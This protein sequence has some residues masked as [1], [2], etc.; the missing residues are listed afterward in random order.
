MTARA[1]PRFRPALRLLIGLAVFAALP[2]GA[3]WAQSS[4]PRKSPRKWAVGVDLGVALGG[5]T[6]GGSPGQ[7]FQPGVTFTAA[8]GQPSRSIPSWFYG[9]G[10]ILFNQVQA[11][12]ASRY[13]QHFPAITPIDPVLTG[14]SGHRSGAVPSFALRATRRI[15]PRYAIDFA[16][17]HRGSGLEL[18]GG[19]QSALD[20]A[21]DNFQAALTGLIGTIPQ[22]DVNVTTS[23]TQSKSGGGQSSLTAEAVITL[24]TRGK[25]TVHAIAGGGVLFRGDGS[26]DVKLTGAYTFSIFG[27]FPINETD[28]VT[29]HL[30]ESG[31]SA[32]GAVGGGITYDLTP[33][34]GIRVDGRLYLSSS[35][36]TTH[37]DARPTVRRVSPGSAL[38]SETTPSIQFSTVPNI[39]TSLSGAATA[40]NT[41][42]GSG[43]EIR[44]QISFGYFVRF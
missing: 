7:P 37:V 40:L 27:V 19:A 6:P 33:R 9:D 41:F 28:V 18:T 36:L 23:E 38:P 35:G 14:A 10:A 29:I 2:A 44:P 4:Q 25:L 1:H 42:N 31:T 16:F 17:E 43:L 8:N 20:A 13:N 3:A 21:R 12:F 24:V 26:V 22:N 30:A 39:Q 11:Q 15:S 32:L 34:Q 5:N